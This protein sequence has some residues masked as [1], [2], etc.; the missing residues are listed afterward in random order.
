MSKAVDG[1]VKPLQVRPASNPTEIAGYPGIRQRRYP[2][3]FRDPKYLGA[4]CN[5]L[6]RTDSFRC[7]LAAPLVGEEYFM[8]F[9]SSVLS[10][11]VS[12][13]FIQLHSQNNQ[14]G[15]SQPRVIKNVQ[16]ESEVVSAVGPIDASMDT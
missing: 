13:S 9:R 11:V 12:I 10:I 16:A 6:A 15:S 2:M 8:T 4:K 14:T 5:S 7:K 1:K 3:C